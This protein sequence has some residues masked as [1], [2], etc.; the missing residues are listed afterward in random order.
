MK[1]LAV[2]AFW[3]YAWRYAKIYKGDVT[4]ATPL[5]GKILAFLFYLKEV[6]LCAKSQVFVFVE[7]VLITKYIVQPK[8]KAKN[9]TAHAPRHVT[10]VG[11]RNNHIFGIPDPDLSIHY[12]TFRGSGDD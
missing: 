4:Y 12:T 5:L 9:R 10:W 8:L 2:L 7:H 11:V 6:E 1:S 3:R